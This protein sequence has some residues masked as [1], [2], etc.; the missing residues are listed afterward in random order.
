[1]TGILGATGLLC[2]AGGTDVY[3]RKH[4]GP[5]RAT[6]RDPFSDNNT[7]QLTTV[8]VVTICKTGTVPSHK[9][10]KDSVFGDF[11]MMKI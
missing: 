6:Q 5:M 7:L 8:Q 3:D 9:A 4:A 10:A 2:I 11:S 1:M